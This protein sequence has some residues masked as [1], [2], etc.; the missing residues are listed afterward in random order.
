MSHPAEQDRP[1]RRVDRLLAFAFFSGPVAWLVDLQASYVLVGFAC[2]H[3]VT[4]PL[5][6]LTLVLVAVP[7]AGAAAALRARGL[8]PEGAGEARADRIRFV[9]WTALAMC[10]LF[11]LLV[12]AMGL[13]KLVHAPCDVF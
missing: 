6:L 3:L 12:L 4:W 11:G 13:A 5:H 8:V 2:R 7:A 10:A 1:V 9:A